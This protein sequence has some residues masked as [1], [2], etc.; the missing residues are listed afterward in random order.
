LIRMYECMT[1]LNIMDHLFYDA[2][3]QGRMSF[4][5]TNHGEEA[6]Q[7]GSSAAMDS[8]DVM[9]AQYRE[10]GAILWRGFTLDEVADQCFSNELGHGKGRQMPVHYG[11]RK[12]N[13][14]TISSPLG[15]QIPQAS[16]AAYALKRV[17]SKNCVICYFGDGAASEGDFHPALNFA[18]TLS[19]PVIFFCRNNGI[20]ISTNTKEQ[21]RGDGI[22]SRGR[23]YGIDAIRVDGND[24][25]AVYEA[26][27]AARER[28]VS[29]GKPIL[30]EAMS[31][32]GGHH[33]TSDDSTRYRPVEEILNWR[34]NNNP[35][36]RVRLVLE[37]LGLWDDEKETHLRVE[38]RKKVLRAISRAESCAK[39][40]VE[41]VFTDVFDKPSYQLLR[42]RQELKEHLSKYPDKYHIEL[43][44]SGLK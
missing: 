15:T 41:E 44:K 2:Q 7:V 34:E 27:K 13:V 29:E 12:L 25:F 28:C 31:Y 18:A 16:G 26:T 11:S 3:R 17:G 38:G 23:G 39:P 14:Q 20:A 4:Y 40:S 24:L 32:R 43:Y 9:Y 10:A 5:M 8:N 30:I 37:E 42:Q 19:C 35:I 1:E 36:T 6:E 22:V 21:Y 33:S